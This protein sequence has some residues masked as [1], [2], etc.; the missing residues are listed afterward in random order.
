MGGH[1]IVDEHERILITGANGFIGSRVVD[2]LLRY[3]S[4]T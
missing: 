3:G 4:G 1:Y 2:T